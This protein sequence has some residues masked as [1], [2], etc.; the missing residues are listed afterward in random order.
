[1]LYILMLLALASDPVVHDIDG[2]K[3]VCFDK[4]WAQDL[5][6]LRVDFPKL[7]K[8]VEELKNLVT[9]QDQQ[10]KAY[11]SLKD[12][13]EMQITGF[14]EEIRLLNTKIQDEKAWY[15]N[16]WFIYGLGFVSGIALTVGVI[17]LTKR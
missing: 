14:A 15:K 17:E 8:Q 16:R 13:Y 1:M 12:N 2:N 11:D 9:N 3:F 4:Q 10:I 5:L 7:Q 6:Q